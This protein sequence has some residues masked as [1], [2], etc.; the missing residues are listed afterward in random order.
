MDRPGTLSALA[1]ARV[2]RLTRFSE[3][4]LRLAGDPRLGITLLLV[5]G[6]ANA[7]AAA[8]PRGAWLL[9]TPAYL[10]LL[11][12]VTITGLAALAVRAP[13]GWRGGRHPAPLTGPPRA[14]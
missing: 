5:T 10:I 2:D 9:A 8:V 4:A 11:G 14:L 6:V 3:R 1:G 12:A 7:A 13:T